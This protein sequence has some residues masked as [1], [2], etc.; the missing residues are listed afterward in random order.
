M[1]PSVTL[2]LLLSMLVLGELTPVRGDVGT[3]AS[4][5]PPYLPTKC[6]GYDQD[7]FPPS[8]MFAAVSD[9]LWDNGAACGRSYMLRCLS[10]PNRPC[11]DSIIRVAVVDQCTDP[12]PASFLLSTAAFTAVSRFNDAKINVEF[13]QI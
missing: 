4:Y 8:N 3:A 7:Q 12:C 2:F 10:G 13:A 6:N 5:G 1:R 9:G 11:K